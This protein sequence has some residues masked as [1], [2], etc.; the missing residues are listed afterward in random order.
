M[1]FWKKGERMISE[2]KEKLCVDSDGACELLGIGK[3][4]LWALTHRND[5]PLPF[6]RAGERVIRFSVDALR[7]WSASEAERQSGGAA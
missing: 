5:H 3:N 2:N 4:T 1:Q 7:E 6:F